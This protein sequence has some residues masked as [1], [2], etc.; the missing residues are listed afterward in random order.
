MQCVAVGRGPEHFGCVVSLEGFP[1][2]R[3]G[4]RVEG[5]CREHG[6]TGA[7]HQGVFVQRIGRAEPGKHAFQK[8]WPVV[9]PLTRFVRF[10]ELFEAAEEKR[11]SFSEHHD[12]VPN[13]GKQLSCE[14]VFKFVEAPESEN[15][16]VGVDTSVLPQ[17]QQPQGIA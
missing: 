17:D 12:A 8:P 3:I 16:Q 15:I 7:L 6:D 10:G 13:V 5:V 14:D 4:D 9:C 2:I 1:P 11:M